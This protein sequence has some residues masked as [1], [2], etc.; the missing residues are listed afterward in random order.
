MSIDKLVDELPTSGM[1]VRALSALDFIAP[2]QWQNVTGF[3]NMIRHVTGEQ[4]AEMVAAIRAR[5]LHLWNDSSQSYQRAVSL[6]RL[7]DSADSK[8]GWAALAHKLGERVGLLSFLSRL[9]P[10]EDKAQTVDLALKLALESAAFCYT[11]G[12]PGDSV[13]D[14]AAALRSYEKENLIRVAGL[15]VFEG[16]VPLGPDYA[17]RMA[18]GVRNFDV[19]D[20]ENNAIFQRVKGLIPG[21]GAAAGALSFVGDSVSAVSGYVGEFAGK[22]GV[23]LDGVLGRLNGFIDFSESRLDYLAAFLDVSTNYMEHT[24]IQ[25]VSRSLIERAVGEI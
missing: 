1:T 4:D 15:V 14:F 5:A 19:A 18:E 24:G 11:N 12:L 7:V 3:D 25:S 21:G 10:Q 2:G 8:I 20:I 6:Y 16:L 13:A 9:T 22:H 23:T 17:A